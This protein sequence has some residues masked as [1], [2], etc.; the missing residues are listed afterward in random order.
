MEKELEFDP[1]FSEEVTDEFVEDANEEMINAEIE[2][3][4]GEVPVD[5]ADAADDL[6]FIDLENNKNNPHKFA[7]V[8]FYVN[9]KVIY[10][11]DLWTTVYRNDY[12]KLIEIKNII[13]NF[14]EIRPD[15]PRKFKDFFA[16]VGV[17]RYTFPKTMIPV[18]LDIDNKEVCVVFENSIN[19]Y[20]KFAKLKKMRI[21]IN[22]EE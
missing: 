18:S 9:D 13:N 15:S 7:S 20:I 12:N 2:A 17:V 14:D 22:P 8:R 11:F 1:V 3:N 16:V 10:R 6:Q 5:M 4:Q 19:Q 21:E